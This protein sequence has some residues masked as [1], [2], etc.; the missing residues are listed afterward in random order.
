MK[1]SRSIC[2]L[3]L[4]S[5]MVEHS[6]AQNVYAELTFSS[7]NTGNTST[8][9]KPR[10]RAPAMLPDLPV[11]YY[12]N[13]TI[14]FYSEDDDYLLPYRIVDQYGL[15]ITSGIIEVTS[16]QISSINI[17]SLQSGFY[18]LIINQG[19]E[20]SASFEHQGYN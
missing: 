17:A 8:Q 6:M 1:I 15:C 13:N 18:N 5:L 12:E 7:Y 3:V 11:C 19:E 2:L 14:S 16:S 9:K 10:R 4:S 20:F